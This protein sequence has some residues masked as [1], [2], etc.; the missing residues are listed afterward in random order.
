MHLENKV[1]IEWIMLEIEYQSL[2]RLLELI[3]SQT[4]KLVSRG[5][6][7]FEEDSR[8]GIYP[9]SSQFAALLSS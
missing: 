4:L 2:G 6:Y 5:L 8:L 1:E 3:R 9:K 7:L